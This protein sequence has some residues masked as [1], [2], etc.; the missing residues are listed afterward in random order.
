M[1]K[2]ERLNEGKI[3]TNIKPPSESP[4]PEIKPAPQKPPKKK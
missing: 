1:K 3:K 4:K 2:Y